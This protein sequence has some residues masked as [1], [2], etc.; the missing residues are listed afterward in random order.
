[1]K[2]PRM[3]QK[4]NAMRRRKMSKRK[5]RKNFRKGTKTHRKNTAAAPQRG[6]W[7]L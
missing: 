4:G 7:R 6:G 3:G 5:S 2:T 1:M